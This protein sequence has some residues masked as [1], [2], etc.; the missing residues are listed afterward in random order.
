MSLC[1]GVS[2]ILG[3][4]EI[5]KTLLKCVQVIN[6]ALFW[7]CLI[8]VHLLFCEILIVEIRILLLHV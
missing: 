4:Y 8:F 2:M 1:S 6:I 7:L 5:D 3:L